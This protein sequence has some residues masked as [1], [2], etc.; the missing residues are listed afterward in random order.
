MGCAEQ[1][2]TLPNGLFFPPLSSNPQINPPRLRGSPQSCKLEVTEVAVWI[3]ICHYL[4][5]AL[6][7]NGIWQVL[8]K[9]IS[10]CFKKEIYFSWKQ[11]GGRRCII[12][13]AAYLKLSCRGEI[14]ASRAI[15]TRP[16]KTPSNQM[17]K[18]LWLQEVK[19]N[20]FIYFFCHLSF[21]SSVFFFRP[22]NS[23]YSSPPNQEALRAADK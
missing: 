17:N 23:F 20:L 3:K 15:R 2:P 22:Y 13:D 19:H 5:C 12:S 14:R 11:S 21:K 18:Q 4:R 9:H 1:W 10:H 7:P 8:K 6:A 16:P